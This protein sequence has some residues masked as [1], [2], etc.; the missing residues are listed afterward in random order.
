MKPAEIHSILDYLTYIISTTCNWLAGLYTTCRL[1]IR[2]Q[3]RDPELM[4]FS[5]KTEIENTINIF[6]Q[7]QM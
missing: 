1:V 2:C 7:V 3:R 4:I 6:L 5:P